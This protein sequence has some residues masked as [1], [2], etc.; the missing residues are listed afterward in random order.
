M[1][2]EEFIGVCPELAKQFDQGHL[3]LTDE[4]YAYRISGK[5]QKVVERILISIYNIAGRKGWHIPREH[6]DHRKDPRQKKILE[7]CGSR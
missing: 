3:I 6:V 2:W 4:D 5:K 1:H 7:S